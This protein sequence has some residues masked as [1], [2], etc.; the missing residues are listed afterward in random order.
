MA[1]LDLKPDQVVLDVG[2]GIGGGP[3][4]MAKV[5]CSQH[6]SSAFSFVMLLQK[7][8][9][10]VRG[11][12]LSANMTHIGWERL[13]QSTLPAGQVRRYLDA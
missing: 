6:F 2:S 13:A 1:Y 9:V 7:F 8:G 3:I 12:D 5:S 11:I 10:R 4:Y